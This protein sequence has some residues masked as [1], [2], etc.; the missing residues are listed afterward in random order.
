MP[1]TTEFVIAT[2]LL[3][4]LDITWCVEFFCSK[5]GI[6]K[7]QEE[8]G[9]YGIVSSGTVS[10]RFWACTDRKIAQASGCRVGVRGIERL[11]ARCVK[12]DIVH[13]NAPLS[14]ASWGSQQFAILD[15]SGNLV[16][17]DEPSD[18]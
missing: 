9:A 6:T 11:Y 12:N 2:P 4:F 7:I 18:P 15:P 5:L 8:Q 16:A 14:K 1:Q 13:P 10:I 3:A 17:F